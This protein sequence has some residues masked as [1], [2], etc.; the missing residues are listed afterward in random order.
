[1]NNKVRRRFVY[2]AT[3]AIFVLLTVL[4]SIINGINFTMAANDADQ[5]TRMISED[6]G[7]KNNGET[8]VTVPGGNAGQGGG[9]GPMGPASPEIRFSLRYFTVSFTEESGKL[10]Y[11]NISAVTEDE[12][13]AWA[14]KLAGETTGW[15]RGTYRY[16]VYIRGDK[17]F[18][19]VIDQGRELLPSYRILLISVIGGLLCT[20]ISFF[21]LLAVGKKL[22]KPLEEADR[23]QRQ[24][25]SDAEAEFKV[26]LTVIGANT[27]L[28]ERRN[29]ASEQTRS[30]NRQVKK[31]TALVKRLSALAIFEDRESGSAVNVSDILTDAV[32]GAK[33]RFDGR[34]IAVTAQ[35]EPGVTLR[36]SEE[37]IRGIC[38]Q[39]VDNGVKFALTDARFSLRSA[40]GRIVLEASNDTRLPDGGA[41]QV[42]DRFTRLENAEGIEGDGLGLAFV[43]DA[44][45]AG[46]G[47]AEARVADGRFILKISL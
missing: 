23:K 6:P 24:F 42:F 45:R 8:P 22:F 36:G 31:M 43:K 38:A 13:V 26:P 25:I 9:F 7:L 16:R 19:T 46:D 37:A 20:A 11:Y 12:A 28:I 35:I 33:Q 40:G 39:I 30:I 47:R 29:G 17:T 10:E 27:E 3:A 44:V 14:Q 15:T 1:M 21:I 34:N 5:L 2:S 32:N 18:V 4:L 41:D